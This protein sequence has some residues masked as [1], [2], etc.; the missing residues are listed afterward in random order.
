MT[1][2]QINQHIFHSSKATT[3][4]I[5]RKYPL[6]SKLLLLPWENFEH[7]VLGC[8]KDIPDID[9]VEPF[10]PVSPLEC[11]GESNV[12]AVGDFCL[13]NPIQKLIKTLCPRFDYL[14][15]GKFA[16][17]EGRNIL[18]DP[19][20]IWVT[21]DFKLPKMSIEFKTPWAFTVADIILE[22][23]NEA[24]K[25]R[26]KKIKNK[27]KVM[28]A[29]E[30][31]YIYMTIN[32]HRFGCLTSFNQTWFFKK[33][34]DVANPNQSR[35]LVSPAITCNSNQPYSLTAA[36]LYVI[37]TIESSTEWIYSSPFSSQVSSPSF[38]LMRK[39]TAKTKYDEIELD[40]L[41]HWQD[42]IARSQAGGVATGIFMDKPNV[43]FK[44]IDISKRN[45]GVEQ[46]NK[47][48][49]VYRR[50][51]KLQGICIPRLIA[52][53]NLGGLLQVIVLEHAG[54]SI[55]KDGAIAKKDEINGVLK[56]IRAEGIIHNDLRLPNILID[57]QGKIKIIDF[58]MS[59][60][61]EDDEPNETFEIDSDTEMSTAS[62]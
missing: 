60:E 7:E 3:K 35:M 10:V 11:S 51:K 13:F 33:E 46:F 54:Q 43:V 30:Q 32:R 53:G 56:L 5:A 62:E 28:R 61:A 2:P 15:E 42:I 9:L 26:T 36:W 48:V 34:E 40:G 20:R 55:S 39:L 37:L 14:N 18:C 23:E 49:S 31:T 38:S 57:E 44:T 21:K 12:Q 25:L 17:I 6:S 8:I 16:N 4:S 45:D 52:Y 29:V 19:D 41:M 47:E 22:Y 58:G 1:F 27:G 50:L 59:T 24:K